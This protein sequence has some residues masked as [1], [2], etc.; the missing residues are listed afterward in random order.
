MSEQV[1][2]RIRRSPWLWVA[3]VAL[4]LA[5]AVRLAGQLVGGTTAWPFVIGIGGVLVILVAVYAGLNTG[6]R[7]LLRRV[8]AQR[9]TATVALTVPATSMAETAA[10]LGVDHR[11]I[12]A[13]GSK[14][15]AVAILPDRVELWAGK[16]SE[17]LWAVPR[18]QDGVTLV[19][20]Q[21]GRVT[22][23]ALRIAAGN[24]DEQE[25][26]VRAVPLPVWLDALRKHRQAAMEQLVRDLGQDP[27]R[28]LGSAS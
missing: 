4:G 22:A 10:R 18:R 8:A 12:K 16:G 9:P 20:P 21:I 5:A 24:A 17:P 19:H 15:A 1:G 23:D 2:S 26:V 11:L 6:A 13:D 27:A 25:I 14:Y 7:A 28:V 3:V